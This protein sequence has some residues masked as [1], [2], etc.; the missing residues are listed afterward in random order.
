VPNVPT[1]LRLVR[2]DDLL[3]LDIEPLNMQLSADGLR[4]ERVGPD[5]PAV[6][7]VSLP[8]QHVA[9]QAFFEFEGSLEPAGS[10]PVGAIV[11]GPTRLAFTLPDDRASIPFTAEGLLD[12][13]GFVPRLAPNALPP[14]TSDGPS[15]GVPAADR[16]AIEFPYRLLLSPDAAGRWTHRLIPFT[17]GGRTEL[18]HTRLSSDRSPTPVRAVG[19]R[20]VP[21]ALRTSLSDRDLDDIVTLS[22][23]FSVHPRSWHEMGIPL[24]VWWQRMR[25]AGLLGFDYVPLPLDAEELMLTA[26]GASA[27]LRGRWHYP[28][29]DQDRATLQ[30]LGMPTPSLEQYEHIAGLGRDQYVRVVRR[31][32]VHPGMRASIVKVTERRFEPKQLRTEQSPQGPIGI[33]GATAYL[34]QYF[35]VVIQEPSLDYAALASGYP[36]WGRE[37]P[38]RSIRM[39]TLESPKIDLP[40]GISTDALQQMARAQWIVTH[41]LQPVDELAVARLAQQ[42][43]ESRLAQPFWITVGGADFEF[44]YTATDWER[45]PVSGTMPL[46][47]VPY[48]VVSRTA[49]VQQAF[50]QGAAG[51]RTRPLG[52]QRLALADPADS[53][54]DSTRLLTERMTFDLPSVPPGRT[55]PATY[56]PGWVLAVRS[57]SVHLEAADQLSG[58]PAPVDVTF[59]SSYLTDGLASPANA[60]G[61]FARLAAAVPVAFPATQGGG[62]ARPDMVLEL[63]SSRQGALPGAFAKGAV[64]VADLAAAFSGAKILG[65]F[66]LADV[67]AE[68]SALDPGH[69]GLTDSMSEPEFADLLADPTRHLLVPVLR[70]R[71]LLHDG[72]TVAM[73]ARLV[74]KPRL[75]SPAQVLAFD[76]RSELVLEARVVTPSDGASPTATVRGELRHFAMTFF[77]VARVQLDLLRFLALPERK[78][79]VTAEGLDLRFQGPLQ[80]VNTLR[81]I[82]P[83]DGFSDPP[84]IAVTPEG[85]SAGFSLAVPTV[86][87]GVFSLQN[88]A[89][90]AALSVPFVGK[91]AGLRFAV[92]ERH[93][94]FLVT[95][96]LFGGG[97]FFALGVSADGVDE[98]EAAIEFGGN[99]SLNLGVAS[100]GIHV[101]AGIYFGLTGSTTALTGYLRCGGYLSVLG[102]ITISIEFYLAFTYR[103]KGGGRSEVWGQATV[104]VSVKVACF[105][106]SVS[107]SLERRFAGAGGDPTFEQVVEPADWEQYC[108]AFAEESQ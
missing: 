30:S 100:G 14:G 28:D 20:P 2:P 12:W 21:D 13:S 99:V 87:V 24:L 48:E 93:H 83:S 74:W 79:D 94:P 92:S 51:R 68:I 53:A 95:V 38:L 106:K 65:T 70:A 76:E 105:S 86:A 97:G 71:P 107:L 103:D 39:T 3:V 5:A 81:D 61:V 57:A 96:T 22:G 91:P 89:L 36:S 47:F 55:L 44:G 11:A 52:N 101:M 7:I 29:P 49:D 66:D 33:F 35:K 25:A 85:I 72:R 15:P 69:F 64:G 102:L 108:L 73:E 4:L 19:R 37:M 98:I 50:A 42:L 26:L 59:D 8:A 32:F 63:I 34:R 58:R 41:P 23:D 1:P 104:T 46:L 6:L 17:S 27:R 90:S 82:I 67:V 80:F 84:A 16:T 9:E 62:L 54:P 10:P 60:A 40:D 45:R 88:V 78:P 18:W 56:R 43:L 77:G 31:G 75:R